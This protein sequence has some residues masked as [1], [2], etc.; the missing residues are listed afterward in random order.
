MASI[1]VILNPVAGK[2]FAA[3]AE[4]DIIGY[5]KELE[6]EFDLV[7]TK[8]VGHAIELAEQAVHDG[9]KTVVAVGGDGTNNEVVNGL[10][11]AAAKGKEAVMGT[12]AA[13]SGSDFTHNV[14]VPKDLKEACARIKEGKT[15]KVDVGKFQVPGH[16]VRYFD[17][18]FGI[19][20]DGTV[21]MVAKRYKK[22]R[23]MALYLP[24]VFQT[25]FID[26]K[27][28][29]VN[30]KTD[31]EE[32]NLSTL[33]ISIA[34]GN[35]EGGGF[36]MAPEAKVDDGLFDICIVESLSK[37]GMIAIVPKFMSGAH[38][39]HPK[40]RMLKTKK[41][42][43]TSEDNLIA[44]FDGELLHNIHDI[45]CEIIPRCLSVIY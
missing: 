12:M 35:R 28:T 20:F 5:I 39:N 17:N 33:Q 3:K 38:V 31:N 27:P 19:G 7:R 45:D 30:I 24:V 29:F 2:G 32:F 40:T 26:S 22:L 42:R 43:V 6:L 1:K 36:Y 8:E 14:G 10:M 16:P 4:P 34:N 18:Q 15:R 13:G 41:I 44:H 9:F 11:N 25:I 21:T 23:G 37:P